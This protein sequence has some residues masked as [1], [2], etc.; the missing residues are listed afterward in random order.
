MLA[1]WNSSAPAIPRGR[2]STKVDFIIYHW[3]RLGESYKMVSKSIGKGGEGVVGA[4]KK[5]HFYTAR[6]YYWSIRCP[7]V[8]A[9]ARTC[10]QHMLQLL[11]V[12]I[13]YMCIYFLVCI[14][15]FIVFFYS[16]FFLL[17]ICSTYCNYI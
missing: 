10:E 5:K 9:A 7:A 2:E 14:F 15:I 17:Q 12:I 8:A 1:C 13:S 11:F 16:F 3:N 6:K 4:K